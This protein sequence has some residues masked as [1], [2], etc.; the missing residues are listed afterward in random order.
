MDGTQI[1]S[2]A[3]GGEAMYKLGKAENPPPRVALGSDAYKLIMNKYAP[4]G[5]IK[6]YK[7]WEKLTLSTDIEDGGK[8]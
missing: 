4:D 7:E 5:H 1:G 3:R 8:A 2:P 6:G